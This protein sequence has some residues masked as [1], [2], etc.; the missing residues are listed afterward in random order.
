M[1]T[2]RPPATDSHD[3]GVDA[4]AATMFFKA[5]VSDSDAP[6]SDGGMIGATDLSEKHTAPGGKLVANQQKT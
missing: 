6:I 1:R 4:L 5:A 2:S 3:E